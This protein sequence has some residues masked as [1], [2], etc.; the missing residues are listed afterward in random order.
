MIT[1]EITNA[2]SCFRTII[3]NITYAA[4]AGG[5]AQGLSRWGGHFRNGPSPRPIAPPSIH[6]PHPLLR[7]KSLR[8]LQRHHKV[9]AAWSQLSPWLFHLFFAFLTSPSLSCSPLY[10]LSFP[11]SF[12]VSSFERFVVCFAHG[13]D[14]SVF[15]Y[16]PLLVV[17]LSN[18]TH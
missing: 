4:A 5:M 17:L 11:Y 6:Q 16:F 9:E 2:E 18:E 3:N 1:T 13:L 12:L 7:G 10:C 14:E 15:M 8:C